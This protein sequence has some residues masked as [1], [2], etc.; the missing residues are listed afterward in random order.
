LQVSWDQRRAGQ[1]TCHP[2]RDKGSETLAFEIAK[3]TLLLFEFV[4]K[5]DAVLRVG[6]AELCLLSL[7]NPVSSNLGTTGT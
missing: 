6:I 2:F 7:P 4:L 5:L 3:R 1:S